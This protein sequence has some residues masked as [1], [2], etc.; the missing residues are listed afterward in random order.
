MLPPARGWREIMTGDIEN[1]AVPAE[2]PA[3][4]AALTGGPDVDDRYR[5]DALA[6]VATGRR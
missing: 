6:T 3:T 5:N 1:R 2:D 4:G